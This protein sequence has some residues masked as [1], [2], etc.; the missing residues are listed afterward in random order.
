MARDRCSALLTAATLTA[1]SEAVSFAD[2]PSTWVRISTAR[3]LGGRCWIAARK[4]SSIV[5]R[6][7]TTASGP[8][9]AGASSRSG[10]GCSHG[11]SSGGGT[12]ASGS[13][14][15]ATSGGITRRGRRRSTS[16]HAFVAIRYSHAFSDERASAAKLAR[17]RHARRNVSCTRSSESSNEPSMR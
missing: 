5:S 2:Q 13:A 16:R 4:P 3:C 1:S 8:S 12:G 14:A 6:A 15:A 9:S 11:R 17:L 7:T 10:Y